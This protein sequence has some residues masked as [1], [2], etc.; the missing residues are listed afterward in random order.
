MAILTEKT[1]YVCRFATY[2]NDTNIN[3]SWDSFPM[4][5]THAFDNNNNNNNN[6]NNKTYICT[7]GHLF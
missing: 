7:I 2:L 4:D 5:Y 3:K 1:K 6:N